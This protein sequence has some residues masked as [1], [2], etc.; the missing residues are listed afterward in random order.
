MQPWRQ[1]YWTLLDWTAHVWRLEHNPRH[2]RQ[3]SAAIMDVTNQLA[4]L[5]GIEGRNAA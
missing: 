1:T 3:I 2:S 4:R 5:G